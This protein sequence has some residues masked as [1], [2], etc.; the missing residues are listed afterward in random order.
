M[1]VR[2]SF[3]LRLAS[4]LCVL[5]LSACA[6]PQILT[7][8][9]PFQTAP[10]LPAIQG[11]AAASACCGQTLGPDSWTN[12]SRID[13]KAT[14][15]SPG[16]D[17]RQLQLEGEFVPAD[18]LLAGVPNVEGLPGSASLQSPEMEPG[19][20]Y[21]WQLRLSRAGGPAGPWFTF[22][23]T[24]GYQP[25]PPAAPVVNAPP[26]DGWTDKAQTDL[27]WSPPDDPAGIAGYAFTLD[28][29]P[30]GALPQ[31]LD[32]A[33][34]HATVMIPADGDWY[35]LIRALDNA[36]NVGP[37]AAVPLHL[38]SVPL[39]AAITGLQT[40]SFNPALGPRQVGVTL[41]KAANAKLS[42]LPEHAAAPIRT[43]DISGKTQA[44]V[45]W[46]GKTDNGQAA[47]PGTYQ[48]RVEASDKTGRSVTSTAS[49]VLTLTNKRI[50][51]SL[52]Q[53]RLVA[54]EGDNAVLSS[55]VTTGG[56][57]LPTPTGTFS[58]LEKR[59][60]WTFKSPW[61]KGSPYWYPDSPTTYALL[62]ENS[63]YFIHDAPW[64]SWFGPG[65]NA[66]AGRPGD[67]TTGTH[68]CI[69]APF[70]V[71]QQLFAW[72]DVGTPVVIAP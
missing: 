72:A 64:R 48:F 18:H 51:V 66:T 68:G 17:G 44:V 28:H 31:R 37:A 59:L 11:I 33:S 21:R 53:Q 50:V 52:S 20:R 2:E 39:T 40:S 32:S 60:H 46:D 23:G 1:N 13:L 26:H 56:P 43:F 36:G 9:L 12:A 47:A 5:L 16:T 55:L 25:T 54:Y 65:S 34:T 57:D 30:V 67:A 24:I 38:D 14:F 69:N 8:G 62:F 3:F 7:Q 4:V 22:P 63:G 29:S 6:Q 27:S 45:Q 10:P 70:G 58:V 42:I 19:V 15:D 35:F 41:S 61:P 49:Q 71:A